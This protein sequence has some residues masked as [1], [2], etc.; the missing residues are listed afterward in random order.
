MP[1]IVVDQPRA[2][3][4]TVELD[5]ELGGRKVEV[6]TRR[7]HIVPIADLDLNL[8]AWKA[9]EYE[10]HPGSGLHQRFRL[11]LWLPGQACPEVN[12]ARQSREVGPPQT[13][14]ADAA[15]LCLGDA[16]WAAPE[17]VWDV[18]DARHHARVI[19]EAS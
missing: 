6:Q 2:V 5:P 4:V 9:T 11:W 1:A 19:G 3:V 12:A 16:E 14:A 10:Q 7:R 15:G 8:G 18:Q 13:L 17:R